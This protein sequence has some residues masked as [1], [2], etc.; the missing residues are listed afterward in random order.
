MRYDRQGPGQ[1]G[2]G[3]EDG[4]ED[5]NDAPT[6]FSHGGLEYQFSNQYED[7]ECTGVTH[8]VH[9]WQMQG[10]HGTTV[11]LSCSERHS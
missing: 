5:Q 10:H 1:V 8:L 11:S 3:D 6:T 4:D 9:S 2:D 7:S